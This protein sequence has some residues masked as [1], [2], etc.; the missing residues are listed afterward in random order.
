MRIL[1]VNPNTTRSMT[2][3]IGAAARA[4]AAP[5]TEITAVSP[6]MGPASIEGYYDEAF[7]VPGLLEEV[8][9]GEAAG[10]DGYVV[11]CFDDT[12]V[13]AARCVARGPVL[14]IA[15]A[16][17]HVATMIA[18][19]FTIVSTLGRSAPAL[20]HLVHK[21]GFER[22]CRRVRTAEVP[23]LALEE[24]GSG[25]VDRLRAEIARAVAEDRCEAIVLGC[26]GMADLN[27]R[28]A[29]E[30]G[31]PVIDGVAAAVKLV[32][33]VVG[34]GLGTSKALG[35]APPLA[36]SVCWGDG[37]VRSPSGRR[38][39]GVETGRG[40]DRFDFYGA[41]LPPLRQRARRRD[42]P[43]DL[44]R[45]SR[46]DRLAH[47]RGAAP[48]SPSCS[49]SARA[50]DLLDIACGSGGPSLALAASTGCARHRAGHRGSRASP[51]PRPWPR[52]A[53]LPDRAEFQVADCGGRLPFADGSFDAVLCVD[54]IIHP[55]RPRRARSANGRALLRPGGRLLFTDALVLTGAIAKPE[56]DLRA[57]HGLPP[58]RPGR[59][60]TRPR[61]PPPACRC[62]SVDDTLGG[63]ADDRRRAARRARPTCRGAGRGRKMR[64][65][66][67]SASA[68]S[69]PRPSCAAS[70]RLSR[71]LYLAEKPAHDR[72]R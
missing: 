41:A 14:G 67:T 26:A 56:L 68:S 17:M 49:G 28:L 5:T 43:R 62:C 71:F 21:Y 38:A 57:S 30:F 31:L 8:R 55:A 60:A 9:K 39:D 72:G 1:V 19:S 63:H 24:P 10:C 16:A 23:V 61:S 13:D 32:E 12:G 35:Y 40:R 51:T 64:R 53:G 2:E 59:A 4:V 22:R 36:E 66:S 7:A 50:R 52:R 15:E 42:P 37:A 45:G 33:A 69:R 3:K 44:W 58:D 18:G 6:A 34:L 65:G 11:A 47:R 54:A 48:R 29:A 20:E 25:A 46:A 27:A 70:G